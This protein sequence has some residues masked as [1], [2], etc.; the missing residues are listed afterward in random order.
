MRETRQRGY[1]EK[2]GGNAVGKTGIK[3]FCLARKT[4]SNM[5]GR[6]V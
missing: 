2:A 6:G 3:F 4:T 1:S 5:K